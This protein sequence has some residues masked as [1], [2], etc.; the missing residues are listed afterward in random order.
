MALS[1]EAGSIR[2]ICAGE[3]EVLRGISA[4]VRDEAWAT[5]APEISDLK[6]VQGEN[7]FEVTFNARCR[8]SHVDFAWQ[9]KIAGSTEGILVFDFNGEA[10]I[11][12]RR[13]RIG[14][15][16]LHGAGA[17]G[18]ACTIE[19]IDGSREQ[20]TFPKWIHS[21]APFAGIRAVAQRITPDLEAEVRLEGEV[22]EMEDQRN[23]TDASFKTYCTSLALPRPVFV[24][25]GTRVTQRVTVRLHGVPEKTPANFAQPW[26]A[27]DEVE[28]KIGGPLGWSF[29]S[30]GTLWNK[31]ARPSA[32]VIANLRMLSLA[33]LRVDLWLNASD[34]RHQLQSAA[35]AASKLDVALELA[36]FVDDNVSR[37]IARL[38]AELGGMI[39]VPRIA[40]WLVFREDGEAT[41]ATAVIAVRKALSHSSFIAPVGGGSPDNYAELNRHPEVATAGD[42]TVHACNPQ[43]HAFDEASMIET[44]AQQGVTVANARRLSASRPAIISPIT[45]T[46][47][48]RINDA[49][50]PTGLPAG[51]MPFQID[52]RQN[53]IFA[54]AWK[55]GSLSAL[56]RE[57]AASITG[58]ELMGDNGLLTASGA[59]RALHALFKALA[60]FAGGSVIATDV[61]HPLFAAALTLA[62][63][64]RLIMLVANLG[65]ESQR[66]KVRGSWGTRPI[67]LPPYGITSV[68]VSPLARPLHVVT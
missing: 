54:A 47:R 31:N 2:Y 41:S 8:S 24:A 60:P 57:G 50:A 63:N 19:H 44:I 30:L 48:W 43:V 68:P 58:Y 61:S 59:P 6:V 13:N 67:F 33:H 37:Q 62:Q 12:F 53:S 5:I 64:G 27:P 11:D 45:L 4:P 46:R 25:K 52:P 21:G 39:P 18:K 26:S 29:P 9:V 55:L 38:L 65:H 20:G 66:V 42:F 14:F 15:C 32:E 51:V 10:L 7:S 1:P 23:W 28:V 16:V 3:H 36:V 35:T 34:Y 56:A 22:F 17:S 49:G 40:R